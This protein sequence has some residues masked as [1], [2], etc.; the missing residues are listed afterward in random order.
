MT[1]QAKEGQVYEDKMFNCEVEI[2][3]IN[4][5][6]V[7][8]VD[9]ALEDGDGSPYPNEEWIDDVRAGRFELVDD[10]EDGE[11]VTIGSDDSE[12]EIKSIFDC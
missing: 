3:E 9:T 6:N 11:P 4:E 7:V 8:V 10:V 5:E 1:M 2:I 12:E